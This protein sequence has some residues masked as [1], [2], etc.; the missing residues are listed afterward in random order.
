MITVENLAVQVES[1]DVQI[2]VEV[3][4]LAVRRQGP[5]F[6]IQ[7][8]KN[9]VPVPRF[10]SSLDAAAKAEERVVEIVGTDAYWQA[11]ADVVG[12]FPPLNMVRATAAERCRACLLAVRRAANG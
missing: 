5:E 4:G 7:V 2:A 9:W 6:E 3:A 8:G 10:S 1:V 11:L 12:S